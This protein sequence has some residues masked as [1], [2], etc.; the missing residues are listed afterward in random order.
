[1]TKIA[2]LLCS[3]AIGLAI[4]SQP[5]INAELGR[6]LGAPL[7]AAC[8]SLALSLALLLAAAALWR[9]EDGADF[10]AAAGAPLWVWLGGLSGA[11]YVGGALFIVPKIGAVALFTWLIAGQ[12]LGA[13]AIDYFGLFGAKSLE[14]SPARILG[15]ALVLTGA[16]MAQ[17]T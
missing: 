2:L 14:I 16:W 4:A 15:V 12:V 3:A 8:V 17:K 13:L 9:R 1:M 6:R 5:H 10:S 7:A 11:L